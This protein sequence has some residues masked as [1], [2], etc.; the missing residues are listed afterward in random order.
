MEV[1]ERTQVSQ[2]LD[3]VKI[4][5]NWKLLF[6]RFATNQHKVTKRRLQH[7]TMSYDTTD[8]IYLR[9]Q[10]NGTLQKGV[11]GNIRSIDI[12]PT[13][14]VHSRLNYTMAF[15]ID[16]IEQEQIQLIVTITP[17]AI[18]TGQTVYWKEWNDTYSVSLQLLTT[19]Q[20]ITEGTIYEKTN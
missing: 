6:K 20:K 15:M 5:S 17:N 12:I 19:K 3:E 8:M 4:M 13:I 1:N 9:K 14:G 10:K 2:L 7:W 16:T 11:I 18:L